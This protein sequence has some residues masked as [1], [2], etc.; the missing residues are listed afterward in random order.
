L[1]TDQ[2][3]SNSKHWICIYN[4]GRSQCRVC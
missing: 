4:P 3:Y 1:Q 2:V